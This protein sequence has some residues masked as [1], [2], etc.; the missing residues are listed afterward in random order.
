MKATVVLE[1][2]VAG[3]GNELKPSECM[4]GQM[5]GKGERVNG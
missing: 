2:S 5:E 1:H 4:Q 3:D